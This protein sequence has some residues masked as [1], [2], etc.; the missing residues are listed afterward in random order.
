MKRGTA[1]LPLHY[2]TVPP[3]LAQRMSLLGGAIAEAIVIEYGRPELLRRLSDPFWFQSLGCVL[4]MDWH[5]SG[6]TTSVMNALRK[7]INCRSE[8][9]GVYICGGR[10]K[11]SR[12]TPN[13]L[14][15]VADKTGL[16]GNELVRH[17]KLA[18]KV[19]NTAVQ[20]GFQLYLHTFIVTKEG[21]WAVIQQGMNP[22]ER[23]AR[24]YHWLSSSLRSFM[25]EPHTSVCGRNQGLILNLTDK[26]ATPTKDGIVELTKETP[27][28]LM[29]EV[30]I[31]LPNHHEVKAED[32]NL[33]RLGAAL[34][35]A[36]ETNVTDMESLLLLE[37][38]GPRTLQSLTLVSEVIHGTPSRFSDPARFSFAHGGKDG[39][40]F[41]IPTSVYD[42]TVEVFD[43]AIRQARL[44]DKEKSDAL[45]NLSKISQEMEKGYT[46]SNYFDD[47]VQHERDTSYKYGG[48]TVFGDA[49][50]PLKKEDK[51]K[52]G[53]QLSLWD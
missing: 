10:G 1:D 2:G 26:L 33:K 4:G 28:K 14:L 21:E 8:E 32:V 45:K 41:P 39:H 40:P 43:K 17:S 19:D 5:S 38:V 47:W 9:L 25:E 27:D 36:H 20:D 15:E 34:L 50:K 30:S 52:G 31:I 29:R 18:A 51:G 12:E 23:M 53:I 37:G 48:K 6:I 35:L 13:Q 24:R 42:E 44:G 46:P 49:K 22:N 11:F 7:A 3:W 16:N